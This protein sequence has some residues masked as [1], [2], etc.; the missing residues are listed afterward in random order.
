MTDAPPTRTC[1]RCNETKGI[2]EFDARRTTCRQ[3]YQAAAMKRLE[4]KEAVVYSAELGERI[5]DAIAAGIP[6]SEICV[7]A[8]MP[9]PS[10]VSRWRRT[11]P[12]FAEAYEKA[13]E[14]RAD[15]RSDKIDEA[16]NDLRA[17][18]I[19]AADCRVIVET[20]LKMASK[21]SP[22]KYGDV[23]KVQ[24]EVS[25]PNGAPLAVQVVDDASL[26]VAARWVADLL[27]RADAAPAI[28]LKP[29]S[30]KLEDQAA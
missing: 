28:D 24:A 15:A 9:T 8:G 17:G 18:K 26:I 10:Q 5:T 4:R 1:K 6:V 2:L 13:R 30:A 14:A 25:G 27:S 7:P 20:E 16:L 19:T 22:S 12:E 11:I 23:T 3:C 29:G 21:E